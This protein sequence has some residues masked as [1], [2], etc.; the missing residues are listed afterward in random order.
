MTK[1][2]W[3]SLAAGA[4]LLGACASSSPQADTSPTTAAQTATTSGAANE[5]TTTSSDEP[6]TTSTTPTTTPAT[7]FAVDP[8][9]VNGTVAIGLQAMEGV[10][11]EGFEIAIRVEDI[12]G[13]ILYASLWTDYIESTGD[14]NLRNFYDNVLTQ[15]VPAGPIVVLATVSIGMGPGPVTPDLFG[16]LKCR[17]EVEVPA[18]GET[19]IEIAFDAQ[20][21]CLSQVT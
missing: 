19:R 21:N 15:T 16:S 18:K 9:G 6:T 5:S 2:L 20:T 8:N 11:I 3:P 13:Q 12:D 7:T 17:L 10:F 1:K 14:T 4:V